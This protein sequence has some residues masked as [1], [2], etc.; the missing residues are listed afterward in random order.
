[1]RDRVS[2]DGPCDSIP[3]RPSRPREDSLEQH[4]RGSPRANEY[5]R[6]DRATS[7][8]VD[9]N[10]IPRNPARTNGDSGRY[11]AH[12]P[13]VEEFLWGSS[14]AERLTICRAIF[15]SQQRS[16]P[17]NGTGSVRAAS[18]RTTESIRLTDEVHE[19]RLYRMIALHARNGFAA[20][21]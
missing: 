15:Q 18:P 21:R 16:V 9:R 20:L 14:P 6:Q 4:S 13:T 2:A 3:T 19:S 1:M 12:G 10:P 17:W 11:S 5:L 7:Q 8:P